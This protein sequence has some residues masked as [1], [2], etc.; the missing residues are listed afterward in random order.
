INTSSALAFST[1]LGKQ[2]A[3][4]RT[5]RC[6]CIVPL[7]WPVLPEVKAS[8]AT[9]SHELSQFLNSP[10]LVAMRASSESGESELNKT[11][12]AFGRAEPSAC[13]A[14]ASSQSPAYRASQRASVICPLSATDTSSRQRKSQ[15]VVTATPPAFTTASQQATSMG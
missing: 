7:G 2:S 3:A 4:A 1:Y 10:G 9:S 14:N 15:G 5:S 13:L 6:V 12:R 11:I 8:M